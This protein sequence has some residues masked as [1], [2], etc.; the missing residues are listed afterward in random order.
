MILLMSYRPFDITQAVTSTD[1]RCLIKDGKDIGKTVFLRHPVSVRHVLDED[2]TASAS[3]NVSSV[4]NGTI[5]SSTVEPSPN[6]TTVHTPDDETKWFP[7]ANA[8]GQ[9]G[10]LHFEFKGANDAHV[11][12]GSSSIQPAGRQIQDHYE[13][14]IGGWSNT[15]SALRLVSNQCTQVD[16]SCVYMG[17]SPVSAD[18]FRPFRIDWTDTKLRLNSWNGSDFVSL[19]E[20]DISSANYT[21]D[22]ALIMTG[23]GSS[24][25]WRL[26]SKTGECIQC[27]IPSNVSSVLNGT[28]ISSTVELSPDDSPIL[29]LGNLDI[30]YGGTLVVKAGTVLLFEGSGINVNAGGQL[31]ITGTL[32]K[33]VIMKAYDDQEAWNGIA[34]KSG[35]VPASFNTDMNYVSGSTIQYADLIRAGYTSFGSYSSS[36]GLSL[37]EGVV[38]YIVGVDMIDCAGYYYGSVISIGNFQS[39]AVMRN[40]RVLK[41]NHTQS[42]YPSCGLSVSGRNANAGLVILENANF[43]IA[44][45]DYSFFAASVNRVAVDRSYFSGRALI[46]SISQ[47]AVQLSSFSEEVYISSAGSATAH[48]NTFLGGI[49]FSYGSILQ[50]DRNRIDKGVSVSFLQSS[51]DASAVTNNLITNGR[52]Y[53]HL[54]RWYHGNMTISGNTVQGSNSGG[55]AIH[56]GLTI[57]SNNTIKNCTST[58]YPIIHLIHSGLYGISFFNNNV[59]GSHGSHVFR[60]QGSSNYASNENA[61]FFSGNIATGN[62]AT[63]S[64][65]LLESYPWTNFTMNVFDNNTAPYSVQ[66]DMPDFDTWVLKLP[67]NYWGLFQ[68]DIIDLRT[69]VHDGLVRASQPVV[70]FNPLLSGPTTDR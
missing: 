50:L 64:F 63:E 26:L 16:I 68:A 42:Y 57:V 34:F 27:P 11:A 31:L 69:T 70:D 3:S 60:L 15:K 61:D 36:S 41:S 46:S 29:I 48:D 40:L 4:L 5:I 55:M 32:D 38:P 54:S 47:V 62:S 20:L 49:Q 58:S 23:Y 1:S 56:G 2:S 65:I 8:L 12:L 66:I 45:L 67:L 6:S 14:V 25:Q 10:V 44:T 28:I 43:D 37:G 21:I 7:F 13:V 52:L 9:S 30:E 33:R 39:V 24:G 17:G 22:R 53:Y 51:S 18:E 19:L 35:S 59:V